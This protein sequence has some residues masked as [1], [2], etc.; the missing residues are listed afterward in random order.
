M[1]HQQPSINNWLEMSWDSF[2]VTHK[3]SK[4]KAVKLLQQRVIE[5]RTS[6]NCKMSFIDYVHVYNTFLVSSNKNISKV[7]ETHDKK[8][9]VI[10]DIRE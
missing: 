1:F 4:Q 8:L 3:E 9:R 7:K 5:V 2:P 6:L 10:V